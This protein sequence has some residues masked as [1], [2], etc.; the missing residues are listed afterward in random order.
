MPKKQALNT[1]IDV[2]VLNEFKEK[3]RSTGVNMN[4]II[5]TFMKQFNRDELYLKFGKS[6]N[7]ELDIN[8]TVNED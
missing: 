8:H 5:E 6:N 2:D 7:I 4:V 3:C 1:S